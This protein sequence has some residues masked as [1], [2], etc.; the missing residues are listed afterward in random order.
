MDRL[1]GIYFRNLKN[2]GVDIFE[3]RAEFVD[4][5][6]VRL[7]TSGKTITAGKILIAVGGAPWRPS[8]EELPGVEHTITSNEVFHLE[9]LPKHVV[10]AGGGYIA[11]EFAHIFAG[12]GVPTCLVYRGEEVLRGFDAD[13]RTAVHEGLKEAGVRVVTGSV[14]TSIDK[15]EG[16]DLPLRVSLSTGSH[17]DAD[18]VL[19]AVGRRPNTEGLGCEAAGIE[20]DAMAP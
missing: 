10:I 1:S 17:I 9:D 20:L 3:E 6:T 7:K 5:H 19:M 11:V 8:P 2:A 16:E 18:V 14:F 4:A 13:V 15:R 12:L